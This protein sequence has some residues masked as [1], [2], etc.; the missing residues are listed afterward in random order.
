MS[1]LSLLDVLV[2]DAGQAGLAAGQALRATGLSYLLETR[3]R[4][5]GHGLRQLATVSATPLAA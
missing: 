2:V 5:A 1:L 3:G 4:P